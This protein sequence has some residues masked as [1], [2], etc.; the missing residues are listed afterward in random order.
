MQICLSICKL[1][2]MRRYVILHLFSPKEE[3]EKKEI[4]L[5]NSECGVKEPPSL[6]FMK[7]SLN[8]SKIVYLLVQ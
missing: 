4:C 6:R 5:L 8:V 3:G 1:R 7:L 2:N